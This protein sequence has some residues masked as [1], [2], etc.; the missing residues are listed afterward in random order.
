MGD[1]HNELTNALEEKRGRWPLDKGS[2]LEKTQGIPLPK[3]DTMWRERACT[4]GLLRIKD[5]VTG[6]QPRMQ[7]GNSGNMYAGVCII[8]KQSEEKALITV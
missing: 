2:S 7:T 1:K 3:E 5:L 8:A 4:T 6:S